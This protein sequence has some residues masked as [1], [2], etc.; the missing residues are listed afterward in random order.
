MGTELNRLF[1][2]TRKELLVLL[3]RSPDRKYYLREI[4]RIIGKGQGTVQKELRN[5]ELAGIITNLRKHGRSYYQANPQ[6][7]IFDELASIIRKTEGI[8]SVLK[9]GLQGIDEIKV[10]WIFGS[11]ARKNSD[12]ESDIDLAVIG[13]ISFMSVVS[14]LNPMQTDLAREI[15]PIVFSTSEFSSRFEQHEHFVS[16][17]IRS[18]KMFVVGDEDD[19]RTIL[20]K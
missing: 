6:S 12:F 7:Q 11:V 9:K 14:L 15:N 18:D 16:E 10:A 20:G 17:L 3:L 8:D 5:L 19:L 4:I 1:P 13:D 2:G